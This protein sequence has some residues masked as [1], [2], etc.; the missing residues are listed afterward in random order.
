MWNTRDRQDPFTQ[1]YTQLLQ[2]LSNHH[3]AESRM[4]AA[5]PL[6]ASPYFGNISQHEFLY[7]QSLNLESLIGRAQSVSYLPKDDDTTQR[8]VRGLEE[9]CDRW[10]DDQGRVC[11]VYTTQVFLANKSN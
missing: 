6:F 2:A 1:D 7:Q 3:P 9:L 8:L 5:Q 4:V 10:A 11:M